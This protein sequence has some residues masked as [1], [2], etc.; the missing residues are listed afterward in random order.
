MFGSPKNALWSDPA[1]FSS[2][3]IPLHSNN[4]VI[5]RLSTIFYRFA[6]QKFILSPHASYK[7]TR[8]PYAFI[9]CRLVLFLPCFSIEDVLLN[10]FLLLRF[11][12]NQSWD[13]SA[14]DW[15]SWGNLH[16]REKR[17]AARRIEKSHVTAA[18]LKSFAWGHL[19]TLLLVRESPTKWKNLHFA[20]HSLSTL[21]KSP[22]QGSANQL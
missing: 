13:P 3:T 21:E 2:L 19:N 12:C 5:L 14:A 17:K 6:Q 9:S 4:K 7:T 20:F 22:C 10:L 18:I 8:F 16:R 1:N 11:T 15:R